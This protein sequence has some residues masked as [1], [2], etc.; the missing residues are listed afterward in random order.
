SYDTAPSPDGGT[1]TATVSWTDNGSP[2]TSATGTADFDFTRVSGD[3]TATIDSSVTVTDSLAGTLGTVTKDDPSPK[4]FTYQLSFPGVAGTCTDYINTASYTTNTTGTTASK[5]VRVRV[6]KAAEVS[7]KPGL[8]TTEGIRF[9]GAI[10]NFKTDAD[11]SVAANFKVQIDWGDN[12][13]LSG[14]TISARTDGTYFVNGDHVY[15]DEGSYTL[16]VTVA[17]PSGAQTSATGTAQVADAPLTATPVIVAATE[18][19]A[20]HG[21]VASFTD[22]NPRA[23]LSDFSATIDWGD[24]TTSDGTIQGAG[25]TFVVLGMHTYS[26]ERDGYITKISIVDDGGQQATVLGAANVADAPLSANPLTLNATEGASFSGPVAT[27]TDADPNGT[28]NDYVATIDWGDGTTPSRGTVSANTDGSFTVSGSHTFAEEKSSEAVTVT[29][30]DKGGSTTT[31]K[32]TATVADAPLTATGGFTVTATEGQASTSQTVAT[33]TDANPNAPLSDFS[34]SID[35]GD[36]TT[37]DGTVSA[38]SG[39]GFSVAGGHTYAEEGSYTISVTINDAGGSNATAT[40]N[41]TVADAPLTA[42]GENL[43]SGTGTSF[44]GTVA[45]FTDANP[46]APVSDFTATIDWGDGSSSSAGTIS[47]NP[48]KSF[49]VNGDHT[50]AALGPHTVKIHIVDDGG[51]TADVTSQILSFAYLGQGSF[52]LGDQTVANATPGTTVTWWGAHWS[53]SNSLSGGLP[54]DAM[55]GYAQSLSG[56]PPAAGGSWTT[57]PGTS[58]KP[59]DDVPTYL[60]VIVS[61]HVTQSGSTLSGDIVHVVIVKTDPGYDPNAGHAGTGTIVAQLF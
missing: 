51:S 2:D 60:A 57:L 27:F 4:T 24:G 9:S 61:S 39:G 46:T 59:P 34:A 56:T 36:G 25:G 43:L 8:K 53:N 1:D 18:G 10:A 33:F 54:P 15:R 7:L 16:T 19:I 44:T 28:V 37:S 21:K 58:P 11:P 41:G 47:Q 3:Q 35:W 48:D 29:I 30:N 55:V 32:S 38:T 13:G 42:A 40:S 14:G 50:F 52:V 20:F 5:D 49:T 22:G 12:S 17:D 45:T 26:E 6:C 31:A 23:L